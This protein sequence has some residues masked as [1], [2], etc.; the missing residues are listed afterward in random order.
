[1]ESEDSSSSDILSSTE[2]SNTRLILPPYL[3][4][5]SL[6]NSLVYA[7]E[8]KAWTR[9]RKLARELRFYD[10]ERASYLELEF[11]LNQILNLINHRLYPRSIDR[12]STMSTLSDSNTSTPRHSSANS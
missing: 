3:P 9:A 11:R 6:M 2:T 10:I 5:D 4:P 1:M 7:I 8:R 12:R